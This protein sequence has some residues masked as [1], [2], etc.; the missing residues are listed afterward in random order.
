[1]TKKIPIFGVGGPN[2]KKDK[3]IPVMYILYFI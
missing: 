2:C 3:I 1:M